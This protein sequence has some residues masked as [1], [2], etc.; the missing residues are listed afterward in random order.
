MVQIAF[1]FQNESVKFKSGIS[2]CTKLKVIFYSKLLHVTSFFHIIKRYIKIPGITIILAG[3]LQ[4][5]PI[6]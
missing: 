3:E 6:E 1:N 2:I 4:N 5:E